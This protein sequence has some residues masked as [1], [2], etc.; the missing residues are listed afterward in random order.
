MAIAYGALT[1]VESILWEKEIEI[2]IDKIK[3]LGAMED[4]VE[5][6]VDVAVDGLVTGV[7]CIFDTLCRYITLYDKNLTAEEN[8][9]AVE[10]IARSF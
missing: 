9:Q 8:L 6:A 5:D 1:E 4:A 3:I 2:E 7:L 10:D